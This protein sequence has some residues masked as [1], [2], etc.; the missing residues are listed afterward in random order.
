MLDD[1]SVFAHQAARHAVGVGNIRPADAVAQ[2]AGPTVF[3]RK[4]ASHFSGALDDAA[5]RHRAV[6]DHG[7]IGGHDHRAFF[8]RITD[9]I[10][11]A[12]V[13]GAADDFGIRRLQ[14]Q[15]RRA[16][17]GIGNGHIAK[18]YITYRNSGHLRK[19]RPTDG[20]TADGVSAA[21]QYNVPGDCAAQQAVL[22]IGLNIRRQ[23]VID[24]GAGG[25]VGVFQKRRKFRRRRNAV[26]IFGSTRG[27]FGH[28]RRADPGKVCQQHRQH[29]Y[30]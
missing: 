20:K 22:G 25:V 12:A 26:G 29:Q 21:V 8:H 18:V 4:A 1:T 28:L 10:D 11:R 5:V 14:R 27:F 2:D 7:L 17:A 6:E 24:R 30:N 3:R 19:N 15:H 16:A 13:K 23:T 9:S